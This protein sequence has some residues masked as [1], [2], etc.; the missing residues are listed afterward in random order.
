M[1]LLDIIKMAGPIRIVRRIKAR[2]KFQPRQPNEKARLLRKWANDVKHRDGGKCVACESAT[3]LHAHHIK[4][5]KLYPD[6][7][8]D[9]A[10]GITLCSVCHALEHGVS[11][12]LANFPVWPRPLH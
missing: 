7:A 12:G 11:N 4:P 9:V 8:L 3:R 10:N 2:N 6:M 1:E 5:K